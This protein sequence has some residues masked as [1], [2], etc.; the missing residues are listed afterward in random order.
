MTADLNV[1][2]ARR[3]MKEEQ[4][5]HCAASLHVVDV[6]NARRRMKEEQGVAGGELDRIPH[7]L[8]ARRRMKEEQLSLLS[9][10]QLSL[11]CSTPAG[12]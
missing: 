10:A 3:R 7:V 9:A 11:Q 12:E 1:L 6:L 4:S 5:R 8:N 2:N